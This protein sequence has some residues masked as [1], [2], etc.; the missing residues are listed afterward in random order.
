MGAR[1]GVLYRNEGKLAPYVAAVSLVGLEAVPV[2]PGQAVDASGFDGLLLTGG[3][4]V[5]PALYGQLRHPATQEADRAR[6]EFE[7]RVLGAALRVDVPVFAI[8]RGMQVLNVAMGGSL[9]QD[10]PDSGVRHRSE[11]GVVTLHG[12]ETGQ[13]GVVSA[14]FGKGI[15]QVNSRHHQAVDRP[16]EGI[17]VTARAADGVIEACE[18]PGRR[19]VVGVQWHP[20]DRVAE[21]AQDRALFEAFAQAVRAR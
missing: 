8:C 3:T 11:P 7:L 18:M 14:V 20:E 4:D 12:V 17:V 1:I 16:G 10:L 9:I 15:A 21:S 2:A 13:H 19:F 6:D 5:D